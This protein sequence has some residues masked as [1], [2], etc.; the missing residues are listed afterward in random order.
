MPNCAKMVIILFSKSNAVCVYEVNFLTCTIN[1]FQTF[2]KNNKLLYNINEV[3]MT[4]ENIEQQIV[5]LTQNFEYIKD[6]L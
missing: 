4:F 5:D 3:C 6:C 2:C 1:I